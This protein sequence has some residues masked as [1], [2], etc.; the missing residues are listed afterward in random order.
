MAIEEKTPSA[1]W[2]IPPAVRKVI[3][4]NILELRAV[5]EDDFRRQLSAMGISEASVQQVPAGKTL[6]TDE[7]RARDTA[8]AVIGRDMEGGSSQREA[9]DSFVRETAFTFLNRAVGLRCMEERGLLIV[10]GQPET[11]IKS[12]PARGSSSL[13]WRVRNE[14]PSTTSPRDVWRETL[15]RACAAVSQ[16]VR[17]LF[18]LESEYAAFFPLQP[19]LQKI[20]D[21]LNAPDIAP[22]T[23]AEDEILGWVYQYYNQEEKNAVYA[24]LGKG[25]KIERPEELAAAT[26]L[27]TERYM[28][29]YLLQNTL[30][31]LWME[32]HPESK[33]Y[34][35]WPYY[36]K[37]PEGNPILERE[38]K[39]VREITLMDPCCG[40]GHFLV[41]AFDLYVQM[42]REEGVESPEEIPV[43][44]LERN[45]HGI[46]IDLRAVQI[47]AL[48]LYL[49]GCSIGGPGFRPRRLNLVAADAVLPGNA[50]PPEYM[51]RFDGDKELEALAT[52]IWQGLK[53]VREVG[54]LLHPERVVDEVVERRRK[55]EKDQLWKHGDVEWER[56]KA[57][58]LSGL[59]DEFEQQAQSEDLG[60]RLFGAE[61]AKGVSLMEALGR[62]YD[63]VVTNPPYA[64]SGNLADF[65]KQFLQNEYPLGKRDLYSSFILRC[66]DFCEPHGYSGMVTQQPWLFIQSFRELRSHLL[67]TITIGTL[68]HLG[69]RAFEEI[70]GEV[71]STVLSTVLK[72]RALLDHRLVAL[73]LV[74]GKTPVQ[75]ERLLARSS[76]G[77][78]ANLVFEV[79]QESLKKLPGSMILYSAPPS[80]LVAMEV[81]KTLGDYVSSVNGSRTGDNERFLRWFWEVD[82]AQIGSAWRTY[83]KGGTPSRWMG[84]DE[85]L[86]DWSTE[87]VRYYRE[88]SIGRCTEEQFWNQP[89][90]SFGK[91]SRGTLTSRYVAHGISDYGGPVLT[92]DSRDIIYAGVALLNT[93]F[94]ACYTYLVNP[95]NN[96]EI[97]DIFS[98][99]VQTLLD[100]D[101]GTLVS[102]CR[103]ALV[104]KRQLL[105]AELTSLHFT[106]VCLAGASLACGVEV[107][108]SDTHRASAGMA[109]CQ[110][111]AERLVLN[112]LDLNWDEFE[113]AGMGKPMDLYHTI[114]IETANYDWL[115]SVV[116]DV[117]AAYP[118]PS[119]PDANPEDMLTAIGSAY[120]SLT[121]S[122]KNSSDRGIE[123]QNSPDEGA[124][125]AEGGGLSPATETTLEELS[126]RFRLHPVSVFHL[127]DLV[128]KERGSSPSEIQQHSQ[129][130]ASSLIIHLLGYRW[131]EQDAF[132]TE[133]GPILDP[134]LVDED[135]II[136]LVPCADQPTAEQRL[137]MRLERQFGEEGAA[138]SEQEFRQWVGRDIGEWLRK[139]FFKRHI[140]QFKQRPIA[141][142]F[143]S[144][145]GNFQ[146]FVLY[147]CLSRDTLAKL[148]T[149]Y[150]GGLIARF[151]AEQER[152]KQRG[153][154]NEVT[155]LQLQVEDVEEFRS[156]IE[157]IERG[158]EPKY[159]IRCR[160]KGEEETGRPGPYAPDL[161]DGVK[162]NVRPFQEAGV[163]AA[164]VIKK[165]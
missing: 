133:H 156:R 94:A 100:K 33:L 43:L 21:A 123:D 47:A 120:L 145:E 110:T 71:V 28:V 140:Q 86:I 74:D 134:D 150:A 121:S 72:S 79:P 151:K 67:S 68:A 4:R 136:P 66:I 149:Q 88:S 42:Y 95:T 103:E 49:K 30:G 78:M 65:V 125:V 96:T 75:K 102:I 132:E 135:G 8:V 108:I 137:R 165:W 25:K 54:S 1:T 109:A 162:V 48:A 87:S 97:S 11:A 80:L 39:R 153:D 161:D 154:A 2:G 164:T 17:V 119:A 69:P 32:M 31:A 159:R 26:C 51:K 60:Q 23:Y 128:R 143:T 52:G 24:K 59:R 107:L 64:G 116:T 141:W 160:W 84:N 144:P 112:R 131:P 115:P 70:G 99:P 29:D 126:T 130:Y 27:Y 82:R 10:D 50:P 157:A 83:A 37:P 14:L 9:F 77:R 55:R 35:K 7:L 22:E 13:Y 92:A 46:D 101:L 58:L 138:K 148:R 105:E 142:H 41:R 6:S 18:D 57:D 56:W 53:N 122:E 5:L 44:I 127:L 93:H 91:I 139:D 118:E 111:A 40:S 85:I 34:E 158:D 113:K 62:A 45:L 155:R 90:L 114:P 89:G 61:A 76:N 20:V 16:Q 36:V 106:D 147:H 19:T 104:L 146:A 124:V 38:A 117:W 81:G 3:A 15:Q 152:A 98:I 129:D 63:V 73:R 163:L 12:D